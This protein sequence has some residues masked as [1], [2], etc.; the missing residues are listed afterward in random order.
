MRNH[1]YRL[2]S[3]AKLSV[4]VWHHFVTD[5]HYG[6]YSPDWSWEKF[7]N[8]NIDNSERHGNRK[9]S[10]QRA[11]NVEPRYIWKKWHLEKCGNENKIY[12]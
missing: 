4:G 8:L 6:N 12:W 1:P 2:S 7:T 10:N 5:L 3:V 9:L 11:P